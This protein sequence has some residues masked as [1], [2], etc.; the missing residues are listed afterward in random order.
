MQATISGPSFATELG[1]FC[2][3]EHPV[4]MSLDFLVIL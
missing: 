3:L 4:L 2:D 1:A